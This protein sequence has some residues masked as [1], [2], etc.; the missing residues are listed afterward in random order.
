M[1]PLAIIL[2]TETTTNEP[3]VEVIELAWMELGA[4]FTEPVRRFKPSSPPKWGAMAV[5]HILMSDLQGCPPAA[6]APDALPLAD[7]W[8]GHNIDFDWIA[9]GKPPVKRICT[10]ALSRWLWPEC[11]S[12]TLSAMTYFTKG[13]SPATR[14]LVRGAH[15]AVDDVLM[16]RDLLDVIRVVAKIPVGDLPALYAA[17]E[18]ARIPRVWTFGKHKGKKIEEVDR[19]YANWCRRQPDFDPYV[20]E[21]LR[22]AGL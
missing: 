10:L 20:L 15:S 19:G 6:E 18:D 21:A 11:D 4:L 16:C 13:A 12:H 3:P 1:T 7:Y 5:H 9:L 14:D 22:R 17:S 2:D 8:I